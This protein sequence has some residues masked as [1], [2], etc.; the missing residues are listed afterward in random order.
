M[1]TRERSDRVEPVG[2]PASVG[3]TDEAPR[4]RSERRNEEGGQPVSR[5]GDEA[6]RTVVVVGAG[7]AGLACA[8]RIHVLDPS[9]EVIVLE[10]GDRTGGKVRTSEIAGLAVDE[11][12]DGF[13]ARVPAAVELCLELGLGDELTQPATGGA[14]V[15][16]EGRLTPFPGGLVLGVPTDLDALAGSG[17]VSPAGI[18]R[19][20][21]D[22]TAPADGP[23]AGEDTSVGELVRRRL[24]DEVFETLVAP[25][26]SGINAGDADRLSVAAGAPQLAAAAASPDTPSLI[27]A[28]RRQVAASTV[29]PG[30]PVFRALTGG[31]QRLTDALAAA[32][33]DVRTG[34]G[35]TRLDPTA[36]GFAVTGT[37]FDRVRA[38]AVVLAVPGFAAA[39]LLGTIAPDVATELEALEWSSVALVT[40]AVARSAVE[41]SLEGSGFLVAG[42][43]GLLMTA[44]SFGSNKWAH[45]RPADDTVIL[46]VSAGRHPDRRALDLDDAT[47]V[48][49]LTDEL[50]ATIGLRDQPWAT[51]VSRWERSLPQYRPG[52]LERARRWKSEAASRGVF[53]TGASYLGLGVPACITDAED[54]AHRIIDHLT[55]QSHA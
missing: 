52:H 41:G 34:H 13:L 48:A 1:S 49:D 38:D 43:E 53:L 30:T 5:A 2:G 55:V 44:C 33:P 46:R 32:L 18:E 3:W 22:L 37:G 39:R 10:A 14:S 7:V 45:W 26:L 16:K 25:L 29:T 50:R 51:R 12:V 23:P 35:V 54:T 4:E 28:L 36:S 6:G 9:I 47:L 27:D 17:L 20:R 24:G 15:W 31:T 21:R 19:A 42:G 8:H 11:A 40:F